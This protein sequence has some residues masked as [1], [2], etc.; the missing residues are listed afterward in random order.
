MFG[1]ISYVLRFNNALALLGVNPQHLTETA[2]QSAQVVGKELGATP[3]E[4]AL[5]L[6]SNLPLDYKMQLDPRTAMTWIRKRKLN[7]RN[8]NV[9]E[10]LYDLGWGELTDY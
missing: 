5:V 6:A 9:R 4:M 10:A 1:Q 7:P 2:R 8:P 3:Q